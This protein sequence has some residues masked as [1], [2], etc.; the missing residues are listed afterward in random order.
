MFFKYSE[1]ISLPLKPQKQSFYIGFFFC[2]FLT[3]YTQLK[4]DN[5]IKN[6]KVLALQSGFFCVC[7]FFL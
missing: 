5:I 2:V 1:I 4:D 6:A 3:L 7:I